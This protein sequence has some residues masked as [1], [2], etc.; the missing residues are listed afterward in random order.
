MITKTMSKQWPVAPTT[1]LAGCITLV[2]VAGFWV[3]RAGAGGIPTATGL[4]YAGQVTDASGNAASGEHEIEVQLWDA[5]G[6]GQLCSTGATHV[7]LSAGR[8]SL[9]LPPECT[10]AIKSNA[11]TAA[12][13]LVDGTALGR[14]TLS[15]VPYAVE[16]AHA[17]DADRA[18]QAG[19][20]LEARLASLEAAHDA[21][22]QRIADLEAK[23]AAF[24]QTGSVSLNRVMMPDWTLDDPEP[25]IRDFDYRV[26]FPKPFP[27]PPSVTTSFQLLDTLGTVNTRVRISAVDIDV[28]GFTL[29][30]GTWSN[31]VVYGVDASWTAIS[32]P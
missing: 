11:D 14:T 17:V 12:E 18:T 31:S 26:D 9:V 27:T 7:T 30:V 29:R 1:L 32:S 24:I 2:G 5:A 25:P 4:L 15:A 28:N 22:Q 3:G 10:D 6:T 13:V 8:F 20:A 21:S 19:G 23:V 16:A